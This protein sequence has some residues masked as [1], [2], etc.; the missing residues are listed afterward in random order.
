MGLFLAYSKKKRDYSY[1]IF[2]KDTK[3]PDC[4]LQ[5]GFLV[6]LWFSLH[7]GGGKQID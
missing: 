6:I 1:S 2:I 3:K 4:C 5:S 7:L